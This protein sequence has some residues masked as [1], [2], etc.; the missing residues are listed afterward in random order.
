MYSPRHYGGYDQETWPMITQWT[1]QFL[2]GSGFFALLLT[3][4]TLTMTSKQR[5]LADQH[6]QKAHKMV[7]VQYQGYENLN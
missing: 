6:L 3:T 7:R 1:K 4:F 2:I 5:Q